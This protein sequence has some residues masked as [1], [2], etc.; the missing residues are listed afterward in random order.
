MII[1]IITIIITLVLSAFF[2]GSESALTGASEAY[3]VD[4]EKN[5]HNVRAKIVLNILARRSKA[6]IT[7]LIGSNICNTLG[8][9]LTTQLLLEMFGVEGVAYATLI[10][11]F[12][13]LIYTLRN[14]TLYRSCTLDVSRYC[15]PVIHRGLPDS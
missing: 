4:K 10:M 6:V 9:A 8:T 3:M 2:S 14:G 7:T 13:I 15:V 5:E 12:L 11:T 1:T